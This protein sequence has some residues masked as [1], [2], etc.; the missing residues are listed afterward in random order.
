[1]ESGTARQTS[2]V[3]VSWTRW[4]SRRA[5]AGEV[6]GKSAR[7]CPPRLSSRGEGRGGDHQGDQRR[8]GSTSALEG[9]RLQ[10]PDRPLEAGAV[11]HDAQRLADR[12][13]QGRHVRRRRQGDRPCCRQRRRLG[14]DDAVG[15]RARHDHRLEQ[16]V[17][18][19]AIGA[20][21]AACRDLA[22][23]P[24]ALDGA[25]ALGVR[26]DAAHVVVH[27]RTH[28]DRLAHGIDAGGAAARG[29]AGEMPGEVRAERRPG[30]EEDAMAGRD[31]R[32]H[33]ARDDVARLEL[34][35]ALACHEARAG[36]V[37]Q[38]RALAAHGLADQR[39][40][41]EPDIERGGMELHEL[42]VGQRRAGPRRQRQ[43]L[44]DGAQRVGGVGIEPAQPA[45]RQHDPAARQQAGVGRTS[46][47]HARNA[48]VV[49][50]QAAGFQPLDHRDRGRGLHG[51]DQGAHDRGARAVAR[52]MD[53][54]AAGVRR[55]QAKRQAAG[56][57]AVERPRRGARAR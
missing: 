16:R 53:D 41:I 47:Q 42:H 12:A 8:I 10:M 19:Q 48:A 37:D 5:Q 21:Q 34:A 28:G 33:G 6:C 40:G 57:I 35:A 39:H 32:R 18:G 46:R 24:Q 4:T 49:D 14:A 52:D 50:Q 51:G 54:A 31:V 17:A 30:I 27:R 1:M 9:E 13:A 26:G 44:A 7:Q 38:H 56:R 25:A 11:A 3:P 36:L 22:A 23:G 2:L 20:V 45:G 43:A 29:D 55:L 15:H